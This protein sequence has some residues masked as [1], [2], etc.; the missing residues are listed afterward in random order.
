MASTDIKRA[1]NFRYL[2]LL[3]LLF[4]EVHVFEMQY[5]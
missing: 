3:L 4:Y 2:N 1:K 5:E